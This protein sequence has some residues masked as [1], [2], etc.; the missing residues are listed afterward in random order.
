MLH[1]PSFRQLCVFLC[2][3]CATSVGAQALPD[4]LTALFQQA[5]AANSTLRWRK[6]GEALANEALLTARAARL[7]DLSGTLSFSY[8]GDASLFDRN[9]SHFQ[10]SPMPH[11]G[12]NY[13]LQAAQALY[14]GGALSAGIDLARI[15]VR[16][17]SLQTEADR[18]RLRL[19]IA[20][21]YLD[22]CQLN[23]EEK[24]YHEHIRLAEK[25]LAMVQARQAAGTALRND[26]TRYELMLEQLRLSLRRVTDRRSIQDFRLQQ[27]IGRHPEADDS[28]CYRQA[29]TYRF[30]ISALPVAPA[31]LPD[32][33]TEAIRHTA[34]WQS[35][36]LDIDRA[37]Q[38]LRK[39]RA[40]RL[41]K[42]SLL[43]ESHVD[44]PITIE[45]PPID[46]NLHY[47]FVGVG[48]H[49]NFSALYKQ[50]H[51]IRRARQAVEQRRERLTVVEEQLLSER[52]AA[53]VDYRRSFTE[54]RT[55]RKSAELA[56]QNYDVVSHRYLNQ[57]VLVTD[58][59]DAANARLE[60]DL[61]A[62]NAEIRI[63]YALCRL[64]YAEGAL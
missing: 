22:I 14:T 64:K 24:V 33:A 59:L 4:A 1:L 5:E 25:L 44:G 15:D 38:L 48:I 46:K 12:N 19:L 53:L 18:Q 17:A 26:L 16:E 9:L 49:Y 61:Q 10:R 45:V 60:A 3:L 56:A 7:P 43:A 31:A 36:D 21:H 11:Y 13:S 57:L 51:A 27:A 6:S 55:F 23:N 40:A 29:A 28:L 42:L 62:S 32:T 58:M 39:E 47:W 8:L 52:Q 54:L 63:A 34:A 50:K 20:R 37:A 2:S 30:D 35:A 41:P